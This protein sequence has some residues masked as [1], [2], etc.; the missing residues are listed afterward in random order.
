MIE[1]DMMYCPVC[2]DE[3]RA[4]FTVCAGCNVDLIR[5]SELLQQR[6]SK[7]QNDILRPIGADDVLVT[8]HSGALVEIKGI[9]NKLKQEQIASQI[10]G[11]D[12]SC[13]KGCC[14]SNFLL[15]IRQED[16][17]RAAKLLSDEFT[18]ST[19]LGS[20]DLTHVAEVYDSEAQENSCPACGCIFSPTLAACPECGLCFS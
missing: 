11:D 14:G 6:S 16:V 4:D 2:E 13:S 5:G 17:E 20:Y 7:G 1:P 10:G 9:Q 12:P 8:V 3:Y 19:D 15:Q 18:R